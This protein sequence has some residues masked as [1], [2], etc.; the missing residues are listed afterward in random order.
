MHAL[1]DHSARAGIGPAKSPCNNQS[2]RT[3]TL[4]KHAQAWRSGSRRPSFPTD[5]TMAAGP[6]LYLPYPPTPSPDRHPRRTNM[7]T[8]CLVVMGSCHAVLHAARLSV[9]AERRTLLCPHPPKSPW[10]P[11]RVESHVIHTCHSM[12]VAPLSWVVAPCTPKAPPTHTPRSPFRP[13]ISPTRASN[14]RGRALR[15]LTPLGGAAWAG[16][17]RTHPACLPPALPAAA[18]GLPSRGRPAASPAAA[19]RCWS[20]RLPAGA[21]PC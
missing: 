21:P 10:S 11:V 15:L 13:G 20:P 7:Q 14:A 17:P 1:W 6:L 16:W 18:C 12:N 19:C 4:P 3:W 5:T 8:W 2:I 9:T